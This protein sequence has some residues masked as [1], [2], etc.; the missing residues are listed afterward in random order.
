MLL[1]YGLQKKIVTLS[2][3]VHSVLPY[4]L[5]QAREL[6]HI[7]ASV[8]VQYFDKDFEE[9]VDAD[10]SYVPCHKERLLVVM[11]QE[12]KPIDLTTD[13]VRVLKCR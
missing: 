3:D 11:R 2:P 6:F 8:V 13:Q 9:W 1:T 12:E 10:D 5:G 7:T 4:L